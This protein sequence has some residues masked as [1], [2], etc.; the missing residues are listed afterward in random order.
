[1]TIAP[2][3]K[4]PVPIPAIAL[5]TINATLLGAVAQTRELLHDQSQARLLGRYDVPKLKEH[6]GR[7]EHKFDLQLCQWLSS[8]IGL[9]HPH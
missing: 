2:E 4:P 8:W 1:M 3:N 5:P 9:K 7:N 6:D